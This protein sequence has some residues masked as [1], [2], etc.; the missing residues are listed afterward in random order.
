[1]YTKKGWGR[2]IGLKVV[3][4]GQTGPSTSSLRL[5]LF[6]QGI[7]L[8]TSDA[9]VSQVEPIKTTRWPA[10][11]ERSES[12]GGGGLSIRFENMLEECRKTRVFLDMQS[13]LAFCARMKTDILISQNRQSRR[14]QPATSGNLLASKHQGL[15]SSK[16]HMDF[17]T[18]KRIAN[19]AGQ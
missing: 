14:T 7:R 15:G 1:M 19:Q 9:C 12:N 16:Y 10:M 6:A 4:E 18:L 13:C 5:T 2:S 11:S 17:D 8:A 3:W